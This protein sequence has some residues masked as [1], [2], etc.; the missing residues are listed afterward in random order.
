MQTA[1]TS[2]FAAPA[3][4]PPVPFVPDF[5]GADD[6]GLP[7]YPTLQVAVVPS[8]ATAT[9][10]G[11]G[12]DMTYKDRVINERI[13]AVRLPAYQ[14]SANI[15]GAAYESLDPEIATVGAADGAV[16]RVDDG[17]ARIRVSAGGQIRV[18]HLDLT[19]YYGS[20]SKITAFVEFA[21]G[22]YI[23]LN[24]ARVIASLVGKNPATDKRRFTALDVGL[25][26]ATPNPDLHLAGVDLSPIS[27][28]AGAAANGILITPRHMISSR[29]VM[30]TVG[31]KQYFVGIDGVMVDATVTHRVTDPLWTGSAFSTVQYDYSICLLDADVTAGGQVSVAEF[32]PADWERWMPHYSNR[33]HP[34][35]IAFYHTATNSVG[36]LELSE[37]QGSLSGNYYAA[38]NPMTINA[39]IE[40]WRQQPVGGES[41]NPA[42]I[43]NGNKI[44]L[45]GPMTANNYGGVWGMHV[46]RADKLNAMI[47]EVD[48][49]AG[50]STGYTLQQADFSA[51]PEYE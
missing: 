29:H 30:P 22:S 33:A 35:L 6:V 28:D 11:S 24:N 12:F 2:P 7:T 36:M 18:V 8:Y 50:I 27:I 15:D 10:E 23:A 5:E 34:G 3:S 21:A 37:G 39:A 40:A 16:V 47:A 48:A 4:A 49:L 31:E 41:G 46:R 17:R 32:V 44:A 13:N 19:S 20:M 51:Y 25:G 14:L 9:Y 43:L 42:F 1:F 38:S 45:M 26:T